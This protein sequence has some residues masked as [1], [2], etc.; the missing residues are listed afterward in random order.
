[1]SDYGEAFRLDPNMD[2]TVVSNGCA[3]RLPPRAACRQKRR[4]AAG[5][6]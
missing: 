5:R 1:L 6:P 3:P 4:P 2:G